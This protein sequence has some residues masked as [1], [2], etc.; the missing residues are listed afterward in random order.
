M[1]RGA[2][3]S[4]W[5]TSGDRIALLILRPPAEQQAEDSSC[6]VRRLH[7]R[8]VLRLQQEEEA[9]LVAQRERELELQVQKTILYSY[10]LDALDL[11]P[12]VQ[13]CLRVHFVPQWQRLGAPHMS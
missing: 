9:E 10:C 13:R 2:S 11:G 7:E 4:L 1:R 8:K 3:E 5:R 6:A 12:P